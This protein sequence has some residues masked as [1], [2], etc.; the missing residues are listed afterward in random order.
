[1]NIAFAL[2]IVLAAVVLA[3]A[4]VGI[5]T[6][7][8]HQAR[9]SMRLA[10]AA[11]EV[12]PTLA[13]FGAWPSWN[14]V[15]PKVTALPDLNGHRAFSV[16][17]AHGNAV[18]YEVLEATEP[19]SGDPGRLV[20]RI[21]DERLPFGGAWTWTVTPTASGTDV[22]IVE[23]GIIKN[24]VFRALARTVFGY[25]TSQKKALASLAAHF[26]E[27]PALTETWQHVPE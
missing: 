24:V 21:C 25:T 23:D 26:S 1:M 11:T 17:D 20:T 13:D 2:A 14:A 10:R 3:I 15:A 6:P 22:T 18:P 9:V 12:W 5:F 19:A 16:C 8:R 27:S 7:R 4:I